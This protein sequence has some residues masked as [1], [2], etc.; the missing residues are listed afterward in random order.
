MIFFGYIYVLILNINKY[1]NLDFVFKIDM[2]DKTIIKKKFIFYIS[3]R[4]ILKNIMIEI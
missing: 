1:L 4:I 2:T 3:I